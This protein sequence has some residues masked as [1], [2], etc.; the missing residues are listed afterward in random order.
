MGAEMV[1]NMDAER[2]RRL[3]QLYHSALEHPAAERS[4]FLQSECGGDPGLRREVESLLA[5]DQQAEGFIEGP[6]LEMAAQLVAQQDHLHDGRGDTAIIG[7]T[8]SH[9]RI[10]EKL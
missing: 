4:A 8:I 2:A 9:Y 1:P 3:E 6:A 10:L 5:Y 7:Q